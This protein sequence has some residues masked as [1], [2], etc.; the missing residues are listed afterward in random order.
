MNNP[1][2]RNVI[3]IP[4]MQIQTDTS[5]GTHGTITLYQYD[6]I[7]EYSENFKL[8]PS[9]AIEA[10]LGILAAADIL[11]EATGQARSCVTHPLHHGKEKLTAFFLQR[12]K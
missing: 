2:L 12:P 11:A 9:Q 5:E 3:L 10:C 1:N 4:E 6:A 7:N 8:H